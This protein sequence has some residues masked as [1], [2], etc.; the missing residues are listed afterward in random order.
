V[1]PRV[2]MD[3]HSGV[4]FSS[5]KKLL[6]ATGDGTRGY[7]HAVN[8][9]NSFHFGLCYT[10]LWQCVQLSWLLKTFFRSILQADLLGAATQQQ[11]RY[12]DPVNVCGTSRCA[13]R[14]VPVS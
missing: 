1:G 14:H 4:H 6:K 13:S 5:W 2:V 10:C 8:I 9:C 3:G 7:C 12:T 11:V